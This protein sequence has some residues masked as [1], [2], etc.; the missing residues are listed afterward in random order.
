MGRSSPFQSEEERLAR[1]AFR[2][3]ARVDDTNRKI[4]NG[5]CKMATTATLTAHESAGTNQSAGETLNA[6]TEK[7]S[8]RKASIGT[9]IGRVMSGL[10]IAFMLMAS[11]A[12]KFF[13]PQLAGESMQQLGWN[14]KHLLLIAV[15]E[16]VATVLYAIP[17][18]AALG[19]VL[20][21]GL[22][23]GAVATHL[24]IDNP[25]LSHT[26]FPL[27]VGFLM[28]GG[29]WLR[30]PQVRALLPLLGAKKSA[31]SNA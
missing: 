23:G 13:M 10:V 2:Q 21:T 7:P 9:W 17:R 16:L 5:E 4:E 11:A 30:N 31:R 14:A 19:A 25:L 8:R 12:P 1:R 28:W 6:S 29:L 15:I 20:L 26:L 3:S 22:L 18:T 24:R 27:Y